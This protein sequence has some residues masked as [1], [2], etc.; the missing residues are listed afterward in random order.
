MLDRSHAASPFP[1]SLQLRHLD[2]ALEDVLHR[3]AY[4]PDPCPAFVRGGKRL[5]ARL[6]LAAAAPNSTSRTHAVI[7]RTAA[8]VEL[9]QAGSLLH[10]DIVDRCATRR[11][12]PTV[13]RVAGAAAATFA[14]TALIEYGLGLLADVPPLVRRRFG[15]VAQRLSRGQLTEIL[16]AFDCTLTVADRL[17]IVEDKTASVFATACELGGILT[18]TDRSYRAALRRFGTAFG[19]LFQIADDVDDLLATDGELGRPPG[20]DVREGV[21]SVPIVL[22]LE[23]GARR[24]LESLID[25]LHLDAGAALRLRVVQLVRESGALEGT[26]RLANGFRQAADEHGALLAPAPAT[27]WMRALVEA[28][29]RRVTARTAAGA[30]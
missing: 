6:L 15:D 1:Q 30:A 7:V 24:E 29:L 19:M 25:R 3:N 11:G 23:T 27:A 21:M 13:H 18:T 26:V 8:A 4:L 2:H 16:R 9:L 5:R 12:L 14:A 17:A 28:T 10:D 22:A 20:A